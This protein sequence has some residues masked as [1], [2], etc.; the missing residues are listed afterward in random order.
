MISNFALYEKVV[1]KPEIKTFGQRCWQKWEAYCGAKKG[2]VQEWEKY[3]VCWLGINSHLWWL[4]WT[5][6]ANACVTLIAY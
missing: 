6:V 3:V 2:V 1:C 4:L 5:V